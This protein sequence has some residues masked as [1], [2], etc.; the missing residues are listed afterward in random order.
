MSNQ[1]LEFH[2]LLLQDSIR[3]SNRTTHSVRALV[4][5]LF[6]QFAGYTLAAFVI[7]VAL[8][9]GAA[10]GIVFGAIISVLSLVFAFTAG[11]S[12]LKMSEVPPMRVI[13]SKVATGNTPRHNANDAPLEWRDENKAA[14]TGQG[15][16]ATEKICENCGAVA[17]INAVACVECD[18][19]LS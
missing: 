13:S 10:E 18:K 4:R 7:G 9:A 17:P 11:W 1:D 16:S 12:E 3:A 5:F 19:W 8:A 14:A 15:V 2:S 6:I